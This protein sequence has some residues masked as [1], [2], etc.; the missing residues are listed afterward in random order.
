M[1]D[2]YRLNRR[3][4]LYLGLFLLPWLLMY[5]ARS[6]L[7]NHPDW[8]KS[9]HEPVWQPLFGRE[10]HVP[11]ADQDD[12]RVVAARVLG[13]CGLPGA[14]WAQRQKP[15]VLLIT[16]FRFR[17]QTRLTYQI[18]E[19]RLTAVRQEPPW[20][21][22][23]HRL[24]TRGGFAQSGFWDQLRAWLVD[25]NCV[26]LLAWIATGLVMWWRIPTARNWGAIACGA[27][28]LAFVLFVRVL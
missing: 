20:A 13:E 19:H 14:F 5:G 26:A 17:D 21:L 1:T 15:G 11:V 12:V 27:G 8:F 3:T 2:F 6:L 10:C 16:R 23:L 9:S 22:V 4:H 24:H 7:I 25:L 28:L 18:A